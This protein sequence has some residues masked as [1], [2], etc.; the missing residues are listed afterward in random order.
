M[1]E[2]KA[3][4]SDLIDSLLADYQNPEDLLGENGVLK[5]LTKAVVK[6]APPGADDQAK[7]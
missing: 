2:A 4:P 1:N 3:F 5:R 6:R 7:Y